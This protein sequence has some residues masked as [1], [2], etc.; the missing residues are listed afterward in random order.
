LGPIGIILDSIFSASPAGNAANDNGFPE[1]P[2]FTGGKTTGVLVTEYGNAQF[3]SGWGGPATGMPPGASGYDIVTR[4]HVEGNAAAFMQ[5]QGI[6]NGTLYINNPQI[7]SSCT[8]LLPS[9]LAPGS[10]LTV[11][12]KGGIPQ[13]F[14]GI[15][16]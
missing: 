14:V 2:E 6:A 10:T 4:T 7:C 9:M 11:F 13:T 15:I 5:Q 16:K 3:V 8:S 12:P 1:L